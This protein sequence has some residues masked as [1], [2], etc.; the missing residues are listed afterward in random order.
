MLSGLKDVDREILKHV[1]DDELIRIC[2]IDKKTWNEV[3][4]DNFL[5][6]RLARYPD[7]ER[8]KLKDESFKE[9]F[10]RVLYYTAKM[11]ELYHFE[12]RS[13]DFKEQY[14][15]LKR[16]SLP[17]D[18]RLSSPEGLFFDSIKL[19]F[20]DLV[21]Y[22]IEKRVIKD[23]KVSG[24]KLAAEQGHLEIVKWLVKYGVTPLDDALIGAANKGHIEIVKYLLKRGAN[25][26]AKSDQALGDA[27]RTGNLEMV[28][29]LVESGA[30][31]HAVQD[32]ALR[33]A[34]GKGHL[35]VVKYFVEHGADV[36]AMDG[37]P[38]IQAAYNR[39]LAVLKYLVRQG[40]NPHAKND[41]ARLLA[42][43]NAHTEISE[44]L[45]S[46]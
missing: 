10:L 18:N 17:Y 44:Y 22:V 3:C 38:L 1:D 19:G 13:G 30:N 20:L 5:R 27:S 2:S 24:L 14:E 36:N 46:I 16:N 23:A 40:A 26:H 43:K 41:T 4:D 12:Y 42:D 45:R 29:L 9:F 32:Y 7:I 34:A 21:K 33:I 37:E 15:L 25:V 35:D 8:Y 28:K 11:K 31:I 6:R 39:K